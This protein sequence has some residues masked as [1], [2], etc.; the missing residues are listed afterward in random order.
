MARK[1]GLGRD[2]FSVLEDNMTENKR[3]NVTT[4]RISEI[5]PR[6][7]QPRKTFEEESLR[8]LA[9]SIAEHG[10][11]QPIIVRESASINGL[12][13]IIAGERRWRASK[14]AGLSE[15]P[16]VIFDGNDLKAAQ[17]AIIE[18]V[19]RENLNPLE[20]ALGYRDLIER[21]DLTQEQV[22][23]QVGKSRPTI[24]NMM[25][26]LELPE[27]VLEMLKDGRISA[28]HARTLLS[29]KNKDDMVT[30]AN[31]IYMRGLSVRE[32]EAAVKRMNSESEREDRADAR[33][34]KKNEQTSVYLRELERKSMSMLGRRV[35]IHNEPKKR[36]LELAFVDSEDLAAILRKLCG[37]E[38]FDDD[39]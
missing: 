17:V 10:V 21:F 15:I 20:E 24:T 37:D 29:L 26:L 38:L 8:A 2:F 4:L 1:S 9:D 11:L 7:N 32:I 27:E 35:R 18:N 25:R 3:G 6:Q 34:S 5:E 14:M 36:T 12:Y 13:E 39:N 30:L 23:A 28:G 33:E 19:Q 22:A 16:V 31:K